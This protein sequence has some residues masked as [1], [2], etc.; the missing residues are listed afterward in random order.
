MTPAQLDAWLLASFPGRT[1]NELDA[2]DFPRW[3]RAR[4]VM[5]IDRIEQLNLDYLK[6]R[7]KPTRAEWKRIRQHNLWWAAYQRARGEEPDDDEEDA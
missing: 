2:M 3:M 7:A 4:E 5:E 1:L 6:K